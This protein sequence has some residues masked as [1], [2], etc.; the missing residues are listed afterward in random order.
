MV[1]E[2]EGAMGMSQA[3]LGA[4]NDAILEDIV[5]PNFDAEQSTLWLEIQQFIESFSGEE[6]DSN[7]LIAMLESLSDLSK[8]FGAEQAD[9]LISQCISSINKPDYRVK[10]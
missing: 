5:C 3:Q 1:S 7:S 2:H 10:I 4:P 8:I 9:Y 6:H